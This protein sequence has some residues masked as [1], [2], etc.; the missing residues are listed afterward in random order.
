MPHPFDA[1]ALPLARVGRMFA[2]CFLSSRPPAALAA[3]VA[4]A[5]NPRLGFPRRPS[6]NRGC[7][8]DETGAWPIDLH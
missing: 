7:A 3:R 6:P 2:T 1:L 8:L 5:A 4:L